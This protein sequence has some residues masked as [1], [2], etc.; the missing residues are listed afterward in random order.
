MRGP[1]QSVLLSETC[2]DTC[3]FLRKPT[4]D[5]ANKTFA[6]SSLLLS[7][8]RWAAPILRQKARA[9]TAWQFSTSISSPSASRRFRLVGRLEAIKSTSLPFAQDRALLRQR[10]PGHRIAERGQGLK[11]ASSQAGQIGEVGKQ[12]MPLGVV[13]GQQPG[14]R[15]PLPDQ[16]NSTIPS[17]CRSLSATNSVTTKSFP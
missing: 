14:G 3:A 9:P 16:L 12:R 10:K 7:Q 6:L 15:N 11:L 5:Y 13:L 1:R 4:G 17:V 2:Y 8:V